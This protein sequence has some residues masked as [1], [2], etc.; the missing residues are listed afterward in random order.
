MTVAYISHPSSLLHVMGDAHPECPDRITAISD[1]LIATGL[2]SHLLHYEAPAA[3]AEQIARAHVAGFYERMRAASP[4]SGLRYLDPDTALSPHTLDAALHA[5]GASVMAADLVCSGQVQRAFCNVRPPGHHA[6]AATAMGFC[7]FNNVAIGIRHAMAVHGIRRVAL[8]DFDVHHGNGSEDIFAGD[9]SVLMLSTFQSQLY[10]F[11][12][13]VARG[14]N[15]CS[16]PLPAY[17][18][19]S[20]MREA[21]TGHWLPRLA[22]FQ[23]QMI[24]VSAGFD[25]H[26]RDELAQLRWVEADY[27]W[28]SQQIRAVADRYSQG[29]IVSSLEGGY[30]LQ[31]L[32]RCVE[33]HL[34]VLLDIEG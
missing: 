7:F 21:V 17:S 18:E 10:P 11:S 3:S 1:R 6:T 4:T 31:A 24:W 23:P 14:E 2:M 16:V 26:R 13:E 29:R 12:G 34:R 25:A 32:A 15:I 28:I 30:D 8:I 33:E 22:A 19:G 9:M 5:A 20:E 27:R